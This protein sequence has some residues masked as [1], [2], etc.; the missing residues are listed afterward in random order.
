MSKTYQI[1]ILRNFIGLQNDL[2]LRHMYLTN[3]LRYSH[4]CE[5]SVR[6]KYVSKTKTNQIAIFFFVGI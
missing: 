5:K 3:D 6:A 2:R 1:N 4:F